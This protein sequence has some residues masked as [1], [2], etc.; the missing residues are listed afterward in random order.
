MPKKQKPLKIYEGK[1]PEECR[2]KLNKI[3]KSYPEGM[4]MDEISEIIGISQER[5]R[6]IK[7]KAERKFRKAFIEL[8]KKDSDKLM[9]CIED[10]EI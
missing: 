9:K 3:V 1:T 6:Q 5:V 10:G 8:K 2:E 7:N 4:S